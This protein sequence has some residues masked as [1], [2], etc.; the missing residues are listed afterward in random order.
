MYIAIVMWVHHKHSTHF[1]VEQYFENGYGRFTSVL[2][3]LLMKFIFRLLLLIL[4]FTATR[5]HILH[6]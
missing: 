4:F 3:K 1:N 6:K 2:F 5:S